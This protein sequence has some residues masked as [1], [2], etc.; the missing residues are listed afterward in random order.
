M[1]GGYTANEALQALLAADPQREQRQVSMLDDA[2]HIVTHTGRCCVPAAGSLLGDTFCV[3]A[4]MM[5]RDT[6]WPAMAAAYR[7]TKGVL[8]ERLLAALDAAQAEG[9]DLRGRQ[10]AALLVVGRERSPLPLVDLRV[11][12][13]PQ[14]LRQLRRLWRLHQAYMLEYQ[15]VDAVANG[16]KELIGGLIDQ[17]GEIAPDEPYLQCLCAL[18]LERDL[19]LRQEALNILQP[20]I[21]E[22]PQWRTYLE[23]E[24]AIAPAAGCVELDPQLLHDLDPQQKSKGRVEG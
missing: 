7:E 2:G 12:H 17:I 9:G 10:T 22:Q 18:H 23:R 13:D 15:V 4:N 19:G 6:V 21:K 14:P 16:K 24:L 11:D 5:A 1:R 8:A 3:Q 20:L